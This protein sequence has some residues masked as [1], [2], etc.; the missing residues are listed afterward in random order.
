MLS[1]D[2]LPPL[3]SRALRWVR[4]HIEARDRLF[5]ERLF[6]TDEVRRISA[7]IDAAERI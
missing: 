2:Q 7:A 1:P 4:L 3:P 5:G 6:T